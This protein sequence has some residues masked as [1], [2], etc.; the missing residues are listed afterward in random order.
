MYCPRCGQERV[1]QAT[2]FCSR[3]GYQLTATAQLLLTD[4]VP[5]NSAMERTSGDESPRWRGV[6]QGLFLILLTAVLVPLLGIVFRFGLGMPPWFLGVF[7]FLFAGGGLLRTAYALMFEPK[8]GNALPAGEERRPAN[9]AAAH[10]NPELP[11][12]DAS[13]YIPPVAPRVGSWLDT[14]DLEPRSVTERTTKLLEDER[15]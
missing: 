10:A 14:N 9:L 6:K 1:S 13:S 5:A 8:Y 3:C 2:S 12:G 11:A 4:G 15:D 7:I